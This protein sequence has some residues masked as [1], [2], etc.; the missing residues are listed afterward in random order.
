MKLSS[1]ICGEKNIPHQTPPSF[2][3]EQCKKDL[4]KELSLII[5]NKMP[6][7]EAA[8]ISNTAISNISRAKDGKSLL[9]AAA[10]IS[11]TKKA[12]SLKTNNSVLSYYNL[13]S[14]IGSYLY[15]ELGSDFFKK[16]NLDPSRTLRLLH[17]LSDKEA[18][19][20]YSIIYDLKNTTIHHLQS[21]F[22]TQTL[23]NRLEKMENNNI[24]QWD[25]ER[26][27]VS[28]IEKHSSEDLTF[29]A[30][31]MSII[32][33][34]LLTTKYE[35]MLFAYDTVYLSPES[36]NELEKMYKEQR[37]SFFNRMLEL[38]EQDKPDSKTEVV[39]FQSSFLTPASK[40][41]MQ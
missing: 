2:D 9:N 40:E 22:D 15:S 37:N 19:S 23:F 7:S 38:S 11:I 41:L 36:K 4:S 8:K 24:I 14:N 16:E 28:L 5:S 10:I 20:I 13:K 27:I 34:E 21:F 26:S 25:K 17:S 6:L 29:I 33:N 39:K 12:Y 32:V 30:S 18:Q 31:Q 35:N 1:H 3:R